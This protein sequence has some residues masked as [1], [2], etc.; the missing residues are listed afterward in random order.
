MNSLNSSNYIFFVE[1]KHTNQETTLFFSTLFSFVSRICFQLLKK[2]FISSILCVK[3][4]FDTNSLNFCL[5]P[6]IWAI[7]LSLYIFIASFPETAE[8]SMASSG[9]FSFHFSCCIFSNITTPSLIKLVTI[10]LI[11][12]GKSL[13]YKFLFFLWSYH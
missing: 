7:I 3:C 5:F 4:S 11:L 2:C 6:L 12:T 10:S 9:V 13:C 1:Y 8:Y